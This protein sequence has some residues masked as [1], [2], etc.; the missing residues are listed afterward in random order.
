[1]NIP[2]KKD[3]EYLL[4][5]RNIYIKAIKMGNQTIDVAYIIK[6]D[7][8]F[9]FQKEDYKLILM[10]FFGLFILA[11]PLSFLISRPTIY[12]IDFITKQD[13]RLQ[14]FTKTL[15][16][17]IE[18]KS[19]ENAKKDRLIIHQA[20]LAE[21]GE[22]IGN[23]AHQWRQPLTRLSL[24]LQ[25][26]KAFNKKGVLTPHR[27]NSMLINANE[28]IFFM[29]ETIDNFKD[30]YLP[31]E[32]ESSFLLKDAYEKVMTIVGYDLRHKNIEILYSEES[33]IELFGDINQLSQVLL[34]LITNARDAF[35]EKKIKN[36]II[37][38][39]AK[40]RD[41]LVEIFVSDN[42]GG[43]DVDNLNKIFQPYFSTKKH[44]TGIGLYMVST[45]IESK[46]GGKIEVKNSEDGAIF[47]VTLRLYSS[48]KLSEKKD[49]NGK[50]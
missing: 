25:N 37:K 34:N 30:F 19:L 41:K 33:K 16:K 39:E 49:N 45:I 11:F 24:I 7:V 42:A 44:G 32:E 29:S 5:C 22:M 50:S 14:E 9:S 6:P 47:K 31:L 38:V 12:M 21:L 43:I 28:Q 20:R 23:I 18:E 10:M 40:K 8:I 2:L 26:L 3:D 36:P 35:V 46:F 13:K 15:E 48:Y 27:L 4:E 1:M 17:K